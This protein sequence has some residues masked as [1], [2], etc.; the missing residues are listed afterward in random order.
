[1]TPCE[2][3]QKYDDCKTGSGLVWPC[4]AFVGK[5]D[6]PD[7]AD[8]PMRHK[9]NGNCMPAGGFCLA[10]GNEYCKALKNAYEHGWTDA[11]RRAMR[12]LERHKEAAGDV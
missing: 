8:C 10:N 6:K 9:G 12:I 2:L 5:Q 7:R 11:D 1:M 3:C 4:G